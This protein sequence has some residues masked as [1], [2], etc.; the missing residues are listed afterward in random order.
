MQFLQKRTSTDVKYSLSLS[1]KQN[2]ALHVM[3]HWEARTRHTPTYR[4]T[5]THTQ[6]ELPSSAHL[7]SVPWFPPRQTPGWS[8]PS[9]CP[10]YR[11]GNIYVYSTCVYVRTYVRTSLHATD[12]RKEFE[13]CYMHSTWRKDLSQFLLF[14]V[15]PT[16][17]TYIHNSHNRI[18]ELHT[19]TQCSEQVQMKRT[20]GCKMELTEGWRGGE[21][22]RV[23]KY[24]GNSLI[25]V[26][27]HVE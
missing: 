24:S 27:K 5:C 2:K 9:S 20:C 25:L 22:M 13:V 18:H 21:L 12:I 17:T 11:W 1:K 14:N 23:G 26:S 19:V 10:S 16:C 8:E 15:N 6:R 3:R 7:L 4:H